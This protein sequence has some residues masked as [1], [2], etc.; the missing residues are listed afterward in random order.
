[1]RKRESVA[2]TRGPAYVEAHGL[3]YDARVAP[4]EGVRQWA[5]PFLG[6]AASTCYL[7]QQPGVLGGAM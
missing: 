5:E 4:G 7:D 3:E 1:M 2:G 6:F